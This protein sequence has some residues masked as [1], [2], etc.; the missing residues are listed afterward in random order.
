MC[1]GYDIENWCALCVAICHKKPLTVEAAFRV[2]RTGSIYKR[3]DSTKRT[4]QQT[5]E[6]IDNLRKAGYRW[7]DINQ[8]LCLRAARVYYWRN[9][10]S[11]MRRREREK[12]NLRDGGDATVAAGTPG[13]NRCVCSGQNFNR[14]GDPIVSNL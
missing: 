2:Y 3:E 14:G 4:G 13:N 1:Y 6:E 12:E 5:W 11:Y 9:Y 10:K 7:K 8:M